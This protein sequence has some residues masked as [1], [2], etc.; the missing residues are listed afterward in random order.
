ML[1]S[2]LIGGIGSILFGL[3]AVVTG[4]R[5]SHIMANMYAKQGMQVTETT[6]KSINVALGVFFILVGILLIFGLVFRR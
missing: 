6:I 2:S 5:W 3:L 1:N 4:V